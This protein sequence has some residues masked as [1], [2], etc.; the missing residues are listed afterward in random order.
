MTSRKTLAIVGSGVSGLVAAHLTARL[1]DITIFESD[2]RLGG[3]VNTTTVMIDGGAYAIDVGFVV[4]NDRNYPQFAALLDRLGVK[5][6]PTT[7]SIAGE[8]SRASSPSREMHFVPR[9]C[10]CSPKF[11]ASIARHA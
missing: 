10:E 1:R 11:S 5:S 3:H 9:S 8:V 2:E 7:S 4:Y 6:T